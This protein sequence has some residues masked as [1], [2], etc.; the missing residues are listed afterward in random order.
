M[1]DV[2]PVIREAHRH[3]VPRMVELLAADQLG[4]TRECMDESSAPAYYRAFAAIDADPRTQLLVMEVAGQLVGTLQLNFLPG[5]SRGGAERAQ[6]EAV[7]I[8]EE[9][10]GQGLGHVLVGDAIERARRRG[11][12]LVQLTTDRRRADAHRFYESLGFVPSHV[13]MKLSLEG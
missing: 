7:R 2:T 13:G 10:R 5:L 3:D 4:R 11:C 6:I 9:M 1:S 8:A 12:R